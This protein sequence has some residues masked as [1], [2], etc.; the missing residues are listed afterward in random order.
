MT[1]F[2]HVVISPR[3]S[4]NLEVLVQ[5]NAKK[6]LFFSMDNLKSLHGKLFWPVHFV[7]SKVLFS[8]ASSTCC[9]FFIQDSSLVCHR[10]WSL[11]ESRKSSTWR[12][13]V[14]IQ[15]AL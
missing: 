10:T 2:F 1:R 8:D 6:G 11:E 9:G 4:C 7:P 3:R 5:H 15:F 13:L 14:G 12:Q